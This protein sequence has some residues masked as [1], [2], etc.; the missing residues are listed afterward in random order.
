[1]PKRLESLAQDGLVELGDREVRV[2]EAGRAFLRNVCLV[3]DARLQRRL[4]VEAV[5]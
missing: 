3:F 5:A 1:V 2:T 4:R